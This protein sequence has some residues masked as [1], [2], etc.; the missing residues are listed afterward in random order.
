MLTILKIRPLGL[1]KFAMALP[2]V[3]HG[4]TKSPTWLCEKSAMALV[5]IR[6]LW[7]LN[8]KSRS[9]SLEVTDSSQ[10]HDR[11]L[12]EPWQTPPRSMM[13]SWFFHT[14]RGI[15]FWILK[16]PKQGWNYVKICFYKN[17][18]TLNW[19]RKLYEIFFF[20][21]WIPLTTRRN[22]LLGRL[23]ENLFIWSKTDITFMVCI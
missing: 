3:R 16:T 23:S 19:G 14:P 21:Y 8:S 10:S 6:H 11:L 22:P 12:T 7:R 5:G 9:Q 13:D 15:I 2:G 20:S 17:N 4:S 1:W 18:N